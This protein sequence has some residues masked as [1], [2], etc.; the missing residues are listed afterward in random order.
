[1]PWNL[2]NYL[3]NGDSKRKEKCINWQRE[4]KKNRECNSIFSVRASEIQDTL[5]FCSILCQHMVFMSR[6]QSKQN[7][8]Q[9]MRQS[10]E[11]RCSFLPEETRER[12]KK[13]VC[14][15]L[16]TLCFYC[17][18]VIHFV[19]PF[20][21]S[22]VCARLSLV[23]CFLLVLFFFFFSVFKFWLCVIFLR[24]IVRLNDEKRRDHGTAEKSWQRTKEGRKKNTQCYCCTCIIFTIK[25]TLSHRIRCTKAVH[26]LHRHN[27]QEL[28]RMCM[29]WCKHFAWLFFS[30][31]KF[32]STQSLF[33]REWIYVFV[34][35]DDGERK[36][37]HTHSRET[38]SASS[39]QCKRSWDVEKHTILM[40]IGF[41][42]FGFYDFV[43][44]KSI[45]RLFMAHKKLTLKQEH[46][47]QM[48]FAY[49]SLLVHKIYTFIFFPFALSYINML[50]VSFGYWVFFFPFSSC[51]FRFRH[52][53]CMLDMHKNRE[54]N[55]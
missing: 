48:I 51:C 53:L 40:H 5:S 17:L 39:L 44:T 55:G 22:C 36:H 26:T 3:W 50:T 1:M 16:Y 13:C 42:C 23:F 31:F 41:R 37:T 11:A 19:Y 43:C 7:I 12:K 8:W 47:R 54:T 49:V 6:F 21:N 9:W 46:I 34:D 45:A 20:W 30:C 52:I 29:S 14:L 32:C 38:A 33:Y 24:G 15:R 4:E 2:D 35:F 25:V 27:N 28:A 18:F 10:S